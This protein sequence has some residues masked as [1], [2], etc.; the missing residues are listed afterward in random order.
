MYM[1]EEIIWKAEK[2]YL[3]IYKMYTLKLTYKCTCNK[4]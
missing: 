2:V 4:C 3:D 1:I